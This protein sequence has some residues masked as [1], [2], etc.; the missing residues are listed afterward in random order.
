ML[1]C[2]TLL[3][4]FCIRGLRGFQ[5]GF[6]RFGRGDFDGRWPAVVKLRP[7]PPAMVE[8]AAS[9]QPFRQ[10]QETAVERVDRVACFQAHYAVGSAL[11][12]TAS[13]TKMIAEPARHELFPIAFTAFVNSHVVEAL[14]ERPVDPP[15]LSTTLSALHHFPLVVWPRTVITQFAEWA[16]ARDNRNSTLPPAAQLCW[17]GS[18]CMARASTI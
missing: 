18:P 16:Q 7:A 14:E 12:A 10:I 1:K 2:T 15:Q 4:R 3:G 8:S 5:E 13:G 6:R 11:W 17:T 9:Q